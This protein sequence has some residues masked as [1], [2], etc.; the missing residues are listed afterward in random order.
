MSKHDLRV[1]PDDEERFKYAAYLAGA[2]AAGRVRGESAVRS[3]Y[4][5]LDQD[6]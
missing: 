2:I 4:K 3:L 6:A 1:V 5:A